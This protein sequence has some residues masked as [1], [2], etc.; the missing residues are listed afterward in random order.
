MLKM[1]VE[2]FDDPKNNCGALSTRLG[3]DCETINGMATTYIYILIQCIGT[4]ITGV[5]VALVFEW[6]TALTAIALMPFVVM[7]GAVRAAFR[8]GL[9]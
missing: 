2:W 7:A 5:V 8:N 3:T 1:P 6:R 9:S 4:L